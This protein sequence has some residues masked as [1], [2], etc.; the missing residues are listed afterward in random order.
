MTKKHVPSVATRASRRERVIPSLTLGM[1]PLVEARP[2]KR[3]ANTSSKRGTASLTGKLLKLM[4]ALAA[5]G[6]SG[7]RLVM[8]S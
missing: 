1:V 8:R 5:R 4:R 7:K 2:V 6:V 3:G